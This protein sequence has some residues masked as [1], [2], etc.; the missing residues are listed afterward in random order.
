MAK[1]SE[2]HS[3]N[4]NDNEEILKEKYNQF[5][6]LSKEELN[7]QLYKEVARQKSSGTF[8]YE[9]LSNMVE[10]LRGVLPENDYKNIKRI[11]ETLK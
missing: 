9:A 5:K 8:N 3:T 7:T 4:N 6:N 11:L 10:N 1:L 2:F